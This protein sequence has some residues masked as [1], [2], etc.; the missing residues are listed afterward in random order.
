MSNLFWVTATI[1]SLAFA[2]TPN[3]SNLVK[4]L[5]KAE[6]KAGKMQEQY[7]TMEGSIKSANDAVV[8]LGKDI[9]L[10]EQ[11]LSSKK[12]FARERLG[13]LIKYA[14]PQ[15]MSFLSAFDSM[16]DTERSQVLLSRMLK[17]D[18]KDYNDLSTE[19][20]RLDGLKKILGEEK[21][22]LELQREQLSSYMN[23]IKD[24]IAHKKA[25]LQKI[26]SSQ[27]GS[28]LL[29]ERSRQSA[30]RISVMMSGVKDGAVTND[31]D[32]II[33]KLTSP[34]KG[35]IITAFGKVWDTTTRNWSYNKG[36]RVEAEYGKEAHAAAAGIVSYSGWI[37]GYGRVLIIKHDG[38][39]FSVY[40]HLSRILLNRGVKVE[41][42]SVVGYVGDTGSVDISSLYFELRTPTRDIDPTPLFY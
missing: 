10:K 32:A 30:S 23:E 39:L 7:S 5:D 6:I 36:V 34:L 1:S 21:Q 42:G 38:G 29:A 19:L 9:S 26:K 28:R 41:K 14:V 13:S 11:A 25:L 35:R 33:Q 20:D 40:G 37:P 27:R 3:Y 24:S 8:N 2:S 15:D 17:Q 4:E 31:I 22:K 12:I 16:E 18:M